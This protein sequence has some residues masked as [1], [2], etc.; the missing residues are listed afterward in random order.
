MLAALLVAFFLGGAAASGALLTEDML[1]DFSHRAEQVVVDPERIDAITKE[2]ASLHDELK[3]FNKAL[4][5]TGN[6]L[7]SNYT[8]HSADAAGMQEELDALNSAWVAAQS[9][10]LDHRFNIRDQM[11][12]EE[13]QAVFA[14]K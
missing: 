3:V 14:G 10:V 6:S 13:W 7:K 5:K 4:A 2:V 1:K 12:P 11:T 9:R 8:D